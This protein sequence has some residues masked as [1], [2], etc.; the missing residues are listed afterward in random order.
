MTSCPRCQDP[1]PDDALYCR[2]CTVALLILRVLERRHVGRAYPMTRKR[3]ELLTTL[4]DRTNRRIIAERL[5]DYGEPVCSL[6]GRPGGYYFAE[7]D[8]DWQAL[9]RMFT[10]RAMT[11]LKRRRRLRMQ[12]AEKQ[13]EQKLLEPPVEWDLTGQGRIAVPA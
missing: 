5:R 6:Q 1:M 4:P 13:G 12:R 2:D 8:E 11:I 3:L 9:E 7:T 10:S